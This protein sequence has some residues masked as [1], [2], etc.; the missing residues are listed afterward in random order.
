MTDQLAQLRA[1]VEYPLPY[2]EAGSLKAQADET[3]SWLLAHLDG[4]ADKPTGRVGSRAELESLLGGPPPER[5]QGFSR[6][7]AEFREKVVPHALRLD[8]PRFLAYISS[9]PTFASILAELLAAGTNSFCGTWLAGSGPAQ[10][11]LTVLG[12]FRDILGM[13]ADTRG[14][15]TSGGSEANLTALVVAREPLSFEDR[16]RA[17]LYVT[18]QRHGSVDRAAKVIGLRPDQVRPVPADAG[19]RLLPDALAEAVRRDRLAGRLPWAA[20]ANAGATNT[21]A[22]DP[23]ELLARVCRSERLWYHVDAAYG[24]P[25][26]LSPTEGRALAGIG[27]ADSVTLDP[28]KW[29]AQPFEAGC[30]LMRD[31]RRLAATFGLRPDYLQDVER[32]DAEEIHFADLGLALTRRFRALKVWLSVKALGLDWFRALVEHS[33]RLAD[34]AETLL[35]NRDDFEVLCPRQLSVVCFRYRPGEVPDAPR[36][37]RIN[38]ALVEE[39]RT[40]E[41]AVISSTRLGGRVALRF[42]FVH[43]Q[44]TAGDVDEVVNSLGSLGTR[45]ASRR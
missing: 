36:L 30:L 37:D 10:V 4:V 32:P 21:G 3:L 40:T 1:W 17:V 44:T 25:A 20:V 16:S 38:L 33:C 19:F 13:P 28:H 29:F 9:A 43:W 31:G 15:F 45:L 23:L 42:C 22:V 18:E 5:G 11:E 34:Y 26:A 8:H 12:W 39:L 14:L 6:V 24:W 27:Q 7:L 2:P 41:R 35:R